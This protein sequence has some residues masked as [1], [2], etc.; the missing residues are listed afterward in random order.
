MIR[1][2]TSWRRWAVRFAGASAAV[3][4][5]S[6]ALA[7][8][9]LWKV[10][11]PH[12]TV[13]LFGTIHVLKKTTDWRTPK[14]DNAFKS[15]GTLWEEIKDGDDPTVM[16]PLMIKYGLDRDHPVSSKLDA[17]GKAKLATVEAMVGAAPAQIEPLRPW[18]AALTLDLLPLLK[19]GYD[20]NSGVD[21][22]LKAQAK[23]RGEPLEAFES[24]EQQ[25]RFFADLPEKEEV[26]YLLSTLDDADKGAGLIEQLI[27]AWAAGDLAKLEALLNSDMRDKYPALYQKLLVN[28]NKAFAA[29]I[30]TLLKGEGV[31]FVAVGA[32]HL[33]GRDSVQANLERDGF[34]AVR[35]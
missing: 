1:L 17:K 20:P 11:G 29:K 15:A 13:Y 25:I 24:I 21:N 12:A 2:S 7:E 22:I 8:P 26:D 27:D 14:I 5:A 6:P 16:Q 18:M 32:G 30:E 28:R 23:A 19:A 34:K 9:A 35:Q 33:V 31:S 3:L 10:Q 4:L